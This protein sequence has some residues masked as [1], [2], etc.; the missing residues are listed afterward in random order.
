MTAQLTPTEL[1]ETTEILDV[2]PSDSEVLVVTTT[3]KPSA[4]AETW[5]RVSETTAQ[6]LADLPDYATRFFQQYRS[7]LLAF[8]WL[9]VAFM[10][11]RV[12]AAVIDTINDVIFA[13]PFFELVG[14]GYTAWFI[15]RYLLTSSKRQELFQQIN[16]F[17]QQVL[18]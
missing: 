8:G 4:V 3:D 16:Q 7:L 5:Q 2:D 6:V 18:G 15:N 11:V 1:T 13:Q 14:L 17:K 12:F 10:S 9:F